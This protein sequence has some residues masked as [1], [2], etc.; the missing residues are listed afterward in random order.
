MQKS[1][2][3]AAAALIGAPAGAHAQYAQPP[4]VERH[5][6]HEHEMPPRSSV[7]IFTGPA[8]RASSDASDGGLLVALD[9]GPG[10]AGGRFSGTWVRAGSDGGLS[11]YTAE[12][13]VDFGADALLHPILGA[14]GGIARIDRIDAET[15]ELVGSTVGIGLLRGALQYRLPVDGVDARAELDVIGS[16]PAFRDEAGDVSPWLTLAL[17][18]GVGF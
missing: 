17:A 15:D 1:A 5:A 4:D 10:A 9:V 2:L 3:F 6:P 13:W 18:V 8:L 12:L 14:G 11:Q 7:R 16:V